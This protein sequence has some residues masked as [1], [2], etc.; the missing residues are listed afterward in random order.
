M[1]TLQKLKKTQVGI[2][3]L[4]RIAAKCTLRNVSFSS[5]DDFFERTM[6]NY[7]EKTWEQW[8]GPLVPNLPDFNTVIGELRPKITSL[9][10][11]AH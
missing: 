3:L 7:I 9:L 10:S 6:L 5:P 11:A 2:E 4:R 8:L 1:I